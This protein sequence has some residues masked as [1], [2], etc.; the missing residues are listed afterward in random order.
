MPQEIHLKKSQDSFEEVFTLTMNL[1][2]SYTINYL[3]I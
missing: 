3:N 2:I 1:T